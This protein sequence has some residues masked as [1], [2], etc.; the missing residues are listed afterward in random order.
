M[1]IRYLPLLVLRFRVFSLR[2][3]LTNSCFFRSSTGPCS[4]LLTSWP[5]PF[6]AF[7]MLLLSCVST[8]TSRQTTLLP[9]IVVSSLQSTLRVKTAVPLAS[10]LQVILILAVLSA[11]PSLPPLLLAG[12]H[13]DCH[14]DK[15]CQPQDCQ[16]DHCPCKHQIQGSTSFHFFFLAAFFFFCSFFFLAG[17]GCFFFA[18]SLLPF[19]SIT[20]FVL[21]VHRKSMQAIASAID[22]SGRHPNKGMGFSL[23]LLLYFLRSFSVSSQSSHSC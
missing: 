21:K 17:F 12:P 13:E 22:S 2:P 5:L 8:L 9:A 1:P 16:A 23:M 11:L 15:V 4:F 6:R 10:A 20:P 19:F 18:M 3:P 14:S 7:L